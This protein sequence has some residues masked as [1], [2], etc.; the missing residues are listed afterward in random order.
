MLNTFINKCM[1]CSNKSKSSF[2][3]NSKIFKDY[4]KHEEIFQYISYIEDIN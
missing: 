4:I 1:T 2:K 3:H